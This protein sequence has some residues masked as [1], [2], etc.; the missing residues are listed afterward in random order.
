[1]LIDD[2]D[3]RKNSVAQLAKKVGYVFQNPANQF[4]QDTVEEEIA[5]ILKNLKYDQEEIERLVNAT[6]SQFGLL[7]Y[8][9]IYP[10]YLSVGEQQK[11]A[12][13]SI[14]ITQPKILLL[15]E[16]THGMDY[17][18]KTIFFSY[19]DEYRKKGH[20]V[21]LVT[22]DVESIAEYS[23][24][25]ILL[26]EGKI[27]V[28]D[29]KKNVLSNALLFSPQINRLVQGFKS[30]PQNILNFNELIEVLKAEKK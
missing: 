14:L 3:I 26:S 29:I 8:K 17:R 2:I 20:L 27:V 11:V 12:L 23:D 22:H 25:V 9:D 24:R 4:Y 19:L 7:K 1:V 28:D 21:I 30:L 15:D 16:P 18:Q 5:Y 6:M 10:R 13:A